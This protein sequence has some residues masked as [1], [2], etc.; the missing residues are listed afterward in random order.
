MLSADVN[1]GYDPLYAEV[2]EKN[3]SAYVGKGA[4][5]SKY[6]GARGKSGSNDANAEYLGILRKAFDDAK[7]WN[8]RQQNWD[9]SMQVAV[10]L[11]L[12]FRQ[13]TVWC[14]RYRCTDP[15]YAC[16]V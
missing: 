3:N 2:F 16:T 1:A 5:I 8:T 11:S 14:D 13:L 10:E 9:E 6:T 15:E 4:T 12:I 7:M